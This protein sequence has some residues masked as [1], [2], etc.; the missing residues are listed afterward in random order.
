MQRLRVV[1]AYATTVHPPARIVD[2]WLGAHLQHAYY[3][4]GA[5]VRPLAADGRAE[6]FPIDG[7]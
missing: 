6:S 3:A 5:G 1:D 7:S 2:R 4:R